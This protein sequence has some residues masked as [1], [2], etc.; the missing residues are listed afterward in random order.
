MILALPAQADI[1]LATWDSG[2]SQRGPG[3]LLHRLTRQD[4]PEIEA[5]LQVI[6]ALD[7]D[8]LL[9][10]D[11]DWDLRSQTLNALNARLKTPYPHVLA[12]KP[13]TGIPSGL[14]LNH[15]GALAGPRDALAYG[16]FPGQS[17]MALLSRLPIG[18]PE[19]FTDLLWRD[20]P[21]ANLPPDLTE[22]E[23]ALLPLSTSGHYVIPIDL[24]DKTLTLLAYAATPPVFDGPEDRNGRRN[25]DET[26]L[27]SR[28]LDGSL[29]TPPQAPFVV[30]GKPNLD[31]YDGD[32]IPAPILALMAQL[33]DPEPRGLAP[34]DGGNG[35]PALDT[36]RL[37]S[38]EGLRVDMILPSRDIEVTGAGV[39]WPAPNDPLTPLLEAASPHRPVWVTIAE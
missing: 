7:A 26:A 18:Q 25:A 33:Q 2:M 9:L 4:G 24:G 16:L 17:G 21:G 3:L 28:L 29:G 5:S 37:K 32:G 19:S 36:S 20:L 34:P 8:I 14:D 13:N 35:D 30:I 23:A 6:E 27:W 12:L 1:K 39:M 38:G 11:I 10:T 22:E 31:P 15:D